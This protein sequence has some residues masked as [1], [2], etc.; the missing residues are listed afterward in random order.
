[1]RPLTIAP[2]LSRD[3]ASPARALRSSIASPGLFSGG[4]ILLNSLPISSIRPGFSGGCEGSGAGV[5][6]SWMPSDCCGTCVCGAAT[7][8]AVTSIDSASAVVVTDAVKGLPGRMIMLANVADAGLAAKRN[9][10]ASN[11]LK[12]NDEAEHQ[13]GEQD[14]DRKPEMFLDSGPDP[15]AIAIEQ[16]R[17]QEEACAAGDDR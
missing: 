8:T 11:H 12:G 4:M 10:P 13:H 16:D 5:P 9:G 2:G 14:R 17:G 1:M 7:S 6:C 15:I 3:S